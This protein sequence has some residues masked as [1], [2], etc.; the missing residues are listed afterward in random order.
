MATIMKNPPVLEDEECYEN[1]KNDINIWCKYTDIPDTKQA[2]GIHLSLKGR[3]RIASSQIEL[4]KLEQKDGVKTLLAHLDSVFLADEG[5]MQ[6][7]AFNRLYALRRNSDTSV[8]DFLSQFDNEYFKFCKRD[9][10]LPETVIAFMLLSACNLSEYEVQLVMSSFTEINY[11]NMKSSLKRIFA[12]EM[13]VN[14]SYGNDI[15]FQ[16]KSEPVFYGSGESGNS[17]MYAR[18]GKQWRGGRGGFR[19]RRGTRGAAQSSRGGRKTNPIGKD[20]NVTRCLICE[21]KF[22]WARDCQDAY[23]VM[24]QQVNE[25]EVEKEEKVVESE[26]NSETVHFSLFMGYTNQTEKSKLKNLISE[27]H[28]CAVLDSGC[29]TTVCGINWFE[30]YV[31]ELSEFDNSKIVTD[32]SSSTFTFGDGVTIKSNQKVTLPCYIGG[33]RSTITTDV[34]DCDIPLLLSK[35]SMKKAKMVLDF[36]NDS[37]TLGQTKIALKTSSS[38]HYLFPIIF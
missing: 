24:S 10:K 36:E 35:R 29:S 1:W 19:G 27:S 30:N 23:E 37:V 32:D 17:V 9:M 3:A 34:V 7:A 21:S 31:N 15:D 6:F 12:T 28:G 22:H 8:G 11:N 26:E 38:G 2:L 16:T 4:S 18:G 14:K 13:N 20:G 5:S 33:M 25:K